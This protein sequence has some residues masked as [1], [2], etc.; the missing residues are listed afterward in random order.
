VL[1]QSKR[2]LVN[3]SKRPLNIV[4][5]VSINLSIYQLGRKEMSVDLHALRDAFEGDLILS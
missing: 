4:G 1:L 3:L 2:K 5:V